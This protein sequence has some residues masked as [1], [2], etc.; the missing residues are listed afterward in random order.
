M[1][2]NSFYP[3]ILTEHVQP[4]ARFYTDHFGFTVSFES[5][6]YISLHHDNFELAVLA[7]GHETIPQGFRNPVQGMIL[8]FEVDD[9]DAEYARLI[10]GAGLP[11][12]LDIRSE[13]FGQR[14]FITADPSGVLIDMITNIPPSGEYASQF[15]S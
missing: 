10:Q 5:D 6:W 13:T 1:Q 14:H 2:L 3:V 8:N 15:N 9:V 12:K 4:T 7:S 11:V